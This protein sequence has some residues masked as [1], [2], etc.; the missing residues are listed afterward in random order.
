MAIAITNRRV[1]YISV[2]NLPSSHSYIEDLNVVFNMKY[3]RLSYVIRKRN[4]WIFWTDYMVFFKIDT[5]IEYGYQPGEIHLDTFKT[6]DEAFSYIDFC[7][8][9]IKWFESE[10]RARIYLKIRE[11]EKKK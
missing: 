7:K 2:T 11:K 1:H 8:N 6:S 9:R 5:G 10:E 4:K 3:V